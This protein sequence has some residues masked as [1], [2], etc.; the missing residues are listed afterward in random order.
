MGSRGRRSEAR[1]RPSAAKASEIGEGGVET[2]LAL[3][4][5]CAKEG[6]VPE[7]IS[8]LDRAR[9]QAAGDPKVHAT[10]AERFAKLGR[11]DLAIVAQREVTHLNPADVAA[12]V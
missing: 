7:A 2:L 5:V 6:R 3:A 1:T 12:Q 9:A 10:A 11:L 8:A 4:D